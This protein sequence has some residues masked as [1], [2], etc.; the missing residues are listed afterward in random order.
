MPLK[1][2]KNLWYMAA[3]SE[4]VGRTLL[5]RTIA[6]EPVVMFR[7]TTGEV[8]ALS[9]M[10]PHRFAPMHRGQLKGDTVRC[11][12][13]GL[14]FGTDG[15]C[16]H[17]PHGNKVPPRNARL[18]RFPVEERNGI[19]WLWMGDENR[20]ETSR[21]PDFHWLDDDSYAFTQAKTMEMD[22]RHDLI[23]DNL[24][25]LSHAAFLHPDTLGA[26]AT[27]NKKATV[28][29][30]MQRDGEVIFSNRTLRNSA[31][32]VLFTASGA[33]DPNELVDYWAD[34]RWQPPGSFYIDAGVVEPGGDRHGKG[35]HF[36]SAQ[37]ITPSTEGKS[38]YF[39]KFFRNFST[40]STYVT[41][42]IEKS[43]IQAFS[44]E[45]E[46]MVQ[47]V[48]ERMAGR[49]F[50]DLNPV[51]LESDAPGVQVRRIMQN[52][53]AAEAPDSSE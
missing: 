32:A 13:H 18:R 6:D 36:G 31:P 35:R 46:P 53:L 8:T 9:D 14:R 41:E 28:E 42:G 26:S 10:C 45:D 43:V 4:D 50:W 27:G 20:L 16:V 48:Q 25:D 15:T 44:Q 49:D 12:Y 22:L 47:A 1:I 29:V 11:G 2:A 3:W 24:L 38:Y 51:H 30:S 34:V 33:A 7:T 21:I 52:L 19:V 39:W 17:N 5:P 40:E 37:V 23:V